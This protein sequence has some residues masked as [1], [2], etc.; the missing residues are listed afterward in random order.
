[1]IKFEVLDEKC[2][3]QRKEG[4]SGWDLKSRENVI[5]KSGETIIVPLGI[6]VNFGTEYEGEVRGRSGLSFKGI[7]CHLGTIDNN[8]RGELGAILTNLNQCDFK[9]SK[10]NRICQ[11]IIKKRTYYKYE[12]GKV[13][14]DT[15][16][17]EKGFGS[18]GK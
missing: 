17:G 4:D 9:I 1:M 5:I 2:K 3:P 15:N 13:D 11:L 12:F 18:T 16:R 7:L 10:S 6:K 8:Y 14:N